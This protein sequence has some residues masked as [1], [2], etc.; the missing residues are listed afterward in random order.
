MKRNQ[1]ITSFLKSNPSYLKWGPQ[2][3]ADKFGVEVDTISRICKRL[4]NFKREYI[5]SLV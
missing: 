3:L 4:K 2:R 5:A 1:S